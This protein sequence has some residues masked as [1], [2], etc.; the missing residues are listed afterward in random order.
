MKQ[1]F[2]FLLI[3]TLFLSASSFKADNSG[4]KTENDPT[5]IEVIISNQ[6][7]FNDLVK[8]KLDLS[9]KEIVMNYK[10]LEFDKNGKLQEIDFSVDCKD[11]FQ[12]EAFNN[13]LTNQSHFGFFRDYSTDAK[14]PFGTGNF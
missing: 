13:N 12:G 4:Q 11:G 6:L 10:K 7:E 8:I 5:R 1:L 14:T 2:S 9:Q 3:G